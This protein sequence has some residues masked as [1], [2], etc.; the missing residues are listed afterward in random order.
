MAFSRVTDFTEFTKISFYGAVTEGNRKCPKQN[1]LWTVNGRSV[2]PGKRTNEKPS[3]HSASAVR[4]Q[5]VDLICKRR[6]R[7]EY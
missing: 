5:L 7:V 2:F 3:L 6:D 1:P 4:D